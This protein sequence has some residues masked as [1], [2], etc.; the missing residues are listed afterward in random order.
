MK[1]RKFKSLFHTGSLPVDAPLVYAPKRSGNGAHHEGIGLSVTTEPEEWE[2]IA[3]LG[4]ALMSLSRLDHK[5]GSFLDWHNDKKSISLA[6]EWAVREG[7]AYDDIA[8]DAVW[9]DEDGNERSTRFK[10][11]HWAEVE[12]DSIDGATVIEV[13]T[14]QS[15]RKM[16]NLFKTIFGNDQVFAEEQAVNLGVAAVH[17]ELDGVWWEDIIDY[18]V[19]APRGNILPHALPRWIA[20]SV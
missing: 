1:V 9:Y 7:W 4:G 11:R 14:I 20:R 6:W 17:P 10:S 15:S 5:S 12:A 3:G 2:R 13:D 16:D 8:F 18:E 19:S